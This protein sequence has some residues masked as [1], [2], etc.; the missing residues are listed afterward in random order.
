MTAAPLLAVRD[1][2]VHFPAVPLPVRAVDG[3]GQVRLLGDRP[4]QINV[5]VDPAKLASLD[6]ISGTAEPPL[7]AQVEL[8]RQVEFRWRKLRP[9]HVREIQFAVGETPKQKIADAPLS[10]RPNE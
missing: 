8:E 10:A 5:V 4:R 7:P 2:R 9:Q 3:V 6:L 1:L